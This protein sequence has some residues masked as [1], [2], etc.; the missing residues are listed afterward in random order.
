MPW[1][2]DRHETINT[3]LCWYAQWRWT[4][5]YVHLCSVCKTQTELIVVWMG[6]LSPSFSCPRSIS[7]PRV[8]RSTNVSKRVCGN[9]ELNLLI[10]LWFS[11]WQGRLIAFVCVFHCKR[12]GRTRRTSKTWMFFRSSKLKSLNQLSGIWN[13]QNEFR[14]FIPLQLDWVFR[15]VALPPALIDSDK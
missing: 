7:M 2:T 1:S 6:F 14:H 8:H 3:F 9:C 4:S 13:E 12:P 15:H 5:R 11:D 10:F